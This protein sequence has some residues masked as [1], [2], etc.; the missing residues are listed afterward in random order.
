[1]RTEPKPTEPGTSFPDRAIRSPSARE[2]A[3]SAWSAP[4]RPGKVCEQAELLERLRPI[5]ARGLRVALSQGCFD[6][7]HLGHLRHFKQA[8]AQADLLVVA[9]TADEYVNKGPGRPRF[10]LAARIE[11][12]AELECVDYVVPSRVR[13]AVELLEAL[14]PD[15]Y[16]RG[17]EYRDTAYDDPRFAAERVVVARYGGEVRFSDD[18]LVLS[19]TRLQEDL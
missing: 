8:R 4:T 16:I 18:P 12:L 9:V 11:H 13:T 17:A 15:V 2:A 5:R 1:M 19:S 6:L 10:G 14:Q 7:V 3:A